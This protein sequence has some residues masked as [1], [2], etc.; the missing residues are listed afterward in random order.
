MIDGVTV[1]VV[2]FNGNDYFETFLGQIAEPRWS[3]FL[4]LQ[5]DAEGNQKWIG[6]D[7]AA[8]DSKVSWIGTGN[9][10]DNSKVDFGV[11]AANKSGII[12]TGTEYELYNIVYSTED[13]VSTLQLY[14]DG[15]L[16]EDFTSINYPDLGSIV[17]DNLKMHVGKRAWADTG[18][19]VGDIGELLFYNRALTD[20]QRNDIGAYLADEFNLTTDYVTGG[21]AGLD[22]DLDGDGYVGSSDLDIVRSNWGSAV[23]PRRPPLR[24]PLGRWFRRQRRFGH[25]PRELGTD[26]GRGRSRA[27]GCWCWW[28]WEGCAWHGAVRSVP[29]RAFFAAACLLRRGMKMK[30]WRTSAM[31]LY[32]K[33]RE[34]ERFRMREQTPGVTTN[35]QPRFILH[36]SSFIL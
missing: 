24:R 27:G 25:R 32:S 34:P 8:D 19:L 17:Y 14:V 36:P 10:G 23:T 26:L 30:D 16:V 22:G 11:N 1:Q 21:S 29:V 33:P 4:V 5:Q 35:G 20:Q 15:V 6:Y 2:N 18:Q 9:A 12:T 31:R 28:Y 3:M 7:E 13:G